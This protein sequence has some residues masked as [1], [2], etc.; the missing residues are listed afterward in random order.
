MTNIIFPDD[1]ANFLLL[2]IIAH[3]PIHD[4]NDYNSER[5]IKNQKYLEQMGQMIG[6]MPTRTTTRTRTRGTLTRQKSIQ[7]CDN[8]DTIFNR[9]GPN[10]KKYA[11]FT[12]R[13]KC[14]LS[15]IVTKD[16]RKKRRSIVN[17]KRFIMNMDKTLFLEEYFDHIKNQVILNAV[18]FI[19]FNKM[20]NPHTTFTIP[21]SDIFLICYD[22]TYVDANDEESFEKLPLDA[23]DSSLENDNSVNKS[24][25]KSKLK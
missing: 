20:I 16:A 3:D 22:N 25:K 9:L 4:Y 8:N 6:G 2:N 17:A 13:K 10:N 21:V 12:G 14:H 15:S 18:E 7:N 23:L 24:A 19:F 5:W 1:A 11:N